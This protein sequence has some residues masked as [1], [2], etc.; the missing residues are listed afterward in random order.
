M[1]L[2]GQ[3]LAAAAIA[4][5]KSRPETGR[6]AHRAVLVVDRPVHLAV[7]QYGCASSELVAFSRSVPTALRPV[8]RP[9]T[10]RLPPSFSSEIEKL[11]SEWIFVEPPV[12]PIGLCFSPQLFLTL[13]CSAVTLPL[14]TVIEIGSFWL[15]RP[16]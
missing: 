7:S 10:L 5:P 6:A 13:K 4:P 8:K 15:V 16:V 9:A 11:P 2:F 14:L 1:A 3:T 12:T